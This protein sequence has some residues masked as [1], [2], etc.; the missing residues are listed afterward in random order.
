MR[1]LV[2]QQP[3]GDLHAG[4]IRCRALREQDGCSVVSSGCIA[5]NA[6]L[7]WSSMA[8]KSVSQPGPLD[9]VFA[10]TC[11]AMAEPHDTPELLVSMCSRSPL[12]HVRCAP[13]AR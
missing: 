4:L 13:Q 11:D 10:V 9:T 5:A 8:T 6:S 7:A 2:G 12:L 3:R 1:G